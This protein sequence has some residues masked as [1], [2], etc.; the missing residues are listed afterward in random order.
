MIETVMTY[1]QWEV[2]HNRKI[3]TKRARMKKKAVQKLMGAVMLGMSVLVPFIMDGDVT[4]WF[5][6]IPLGIALL[7]SKNI[8]IY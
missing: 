6:T 3:E 2:I 4:A 1:D 7:F 5:I 8:I